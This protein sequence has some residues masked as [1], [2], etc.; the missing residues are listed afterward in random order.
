M[1]LEDKAI[2]LI[3]SRDPRLQRTPTNNRGFDLVEQDPSGQTVRW[4]EVKAM[5][6]DLEDRPVCL[7]RPQF[8]SAWVHGEAYWLYVVEHAG[9]SDR[10][11]L[12]RIQDPTGKARNFAFDR[13]WRLIADLSDGNPERCGSGGKETDE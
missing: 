9:N 6:G 8:D 5:T 3:L 13:G 10:V 12:L 2:K 4:V 7:S 11:R 1:E